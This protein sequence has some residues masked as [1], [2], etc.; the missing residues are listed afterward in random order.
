MLEVVLKSIS[1]K[2]YEYFVVNSNVIAMQMPNGNY[3]PQAIRYDSDLFFQMLRKNSSLAVYQQKSYS[4]LIKW[5]CLDFDIMKGK[6]DDGTI[7]EL[8]ESC[9]LPSCR[10]LDERGI[11]YLVEYS[12]RRGIHIWIIFDA[13]FEKQVGFDFIDFILKNVDFGEKF[14]TVYGLDKFPATRFGKNKLGKA[15]KLPLSVHKKTN[16]QSM[17]LNVDEKINLTNRGIHT[18]EFYVQQNLILEQYQLNSLEIFAKIEINIDKHNNLKY[19]VQK[20]QKN[21]LDFQ[22]LVESTQNSIVF[23]KLWN[24]IN[25]GEMSYY[26]R[27]FLVGTFSQVDPELLN[28]IFSMQPN[29][30]ESLTQKYILKLKKSLYPITIAYLYDIYGESMEADM[31]PLETVLEYISRVMEIDLQPNNTVEEENIT[32]IILEKEKKYL[33]YNDEVVEPKIYYDLQNMLNIDIQR[34]ENRALRI[35]HEDTQSSNIDISPYYLFVRKELKGAKERDRILVSL[36]AEDRL[37]TTRLIYEFVYLINWKFNSYSYNMNFW[38]DDNLFFP[39][40]SSWKNFVNDI[41]LY[42]KFDIFDDYGIIKLDLSNFYDS[43]YLHSIYS[44]LK[45]MLVKKSKDGQN[46]LLNILSFLSRYNDRIMKAIHGNIKGVPQ[47]PAY[48]RVLAEF[49]LSTVIEKFSNKYKNKN[50]DSIFKFYRYVDDMFIL[51]KNIDDEFLVDI[52]NEFSKVGLVINSEKS[53]DFGPIGEISSEKREEF[54]EDI[55]LNYQVK[56]FDSVEF[57]SD[58]EQNELIEFFDRYITRKGFWDINSANFLLG[59]F[60]DDNLQSYYIDKYYL[61]ILESQ[62]GRGSIFRKF[63][64]II[65]KKTKAVQLFFKNQ[66]YQKIPL[67][68]INEQ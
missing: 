22:K 53:R 24:R 25:R 10:F 38:E 48:A 34:I 19:R 40:W 12:G 17:F 62:Y 15:V 18:E 68:T 65:F 36:S 2:L 14:N 45:K 44:D 5:V 39:Y 56:S 58:S 63:Y 4:S 46:E 51:Y 23:V 31:N 29:Y 11:R 7:E 47:G 66:D 54:F 41:E 21:R 60:L 32:S 28:Y 3:I 35:I 52:A 61:N 55:Y 59:D 9:V 37:L 50:P 20:Y 67:N 6:E 13:F 42:L 49:Y 26:D 27:V 1:K 64:R 16:K 8:Y 33:L 30:D 43:I 57:L